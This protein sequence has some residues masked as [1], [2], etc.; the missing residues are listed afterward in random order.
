MR[1]TVL[2]QQTCC[3][4]FYRKKYTNKRC[5]FFND[6]LPHVKPISEPYISDAGVAS[7]SQ[8]RVTSMLLLPIETYQ[9][10]LVWGGRRWHN[11]CI[12][13]NKPTDSKYQMGTRTDNIS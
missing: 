2:M 13:E 9:K 12:R 3:F 11:A 4:E 1:N 6:L 7:T 5:K 8:V 10:F